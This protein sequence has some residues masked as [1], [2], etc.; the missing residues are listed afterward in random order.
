MTAAV[1]ALAFLSSVPVSAGPTLVISGERRARPALPRSV[2]VGLLERSL[3]ELPSAASSI[4]AER[5]GILGVRRAAKALTDDQSAAENYAPLGYYE[6]FAVRGFPL[7]NASAFKRNGLTIA[8]EASMPMENK[9]RVTLLKGAPGLEPGPAAPGGIVDY[10]TKRPGRRA[11]SRLI[12]EGSMT[13]GR[14]AALDADF[15]LGEAWGARVNAA[16]ESLRPYVTAA[17]GRRRFASLAVERSFGPAA[18]VVFDADWDLRSQLSVPAVQLLGGSALPAGVEPE[19]MLNAQPWSRPVRTEASNIGLAA[20]ARPEGWGLLRAAFNRN[21]VLM[22]DNVAFP[23]GCSSGPTTLSVFCA[24]G[25]Y[26]L[27]DY[28]SP[29][30]VRTVSEARLA[31]SGRFKTGALLHRPALGVSRMSREVRRGQEVFAFL[32]TANL[33]APQ[34]V[35]APSATAPGTVHLTQRADDLSF[36]LADTV[37]LSP[38]WKVLVGLRRSAVE[39]RRA[40][41]AA[42]AS[43]PGFSRVFLVPQAALSWVPSPALAFYASHVRG[44]EPGGTAPATAANAGAVLDPKESRQNELGMRFDWEGRLV[45]GLTAFRMSRPTEFVDASN[46]FSRRGEAVHQGLEGTLAGAP[47]A[48]TRLKAGF[49]W[50]R[51]R[52]RGTGD[53]AL[54]GNAPPNAASL[55]T[56][57]SASQTLWFLPGASLDGAWA[58]VS[59]SPARRDGAASVPSYHRF[60]AGARWERGAVVAALRVENLFDRRYWKDSG[61]AF[62]DGY[63]HLGA[64]RVVRV[65]TELKF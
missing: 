6:G 26:D 52:Q 34:P 62:G 14:Y 65:S 4:D 8:N 63:L 32:G 64:P 61:E 42:G 15:P 49:T 54:D 18:S 1:L 19:T 35:Y 58:F 60:D 27:Y 59:D 38:S 25:D 3:L 48:G 50:L 24:N 13:G 40:D 51:A 17:A 57:F 41:R 23:Y 30:E 44:V 39:E 45:G 22:D 56:G 36:S 33:S 37:A 28:R 9:E 29:G 53:P 31:W 2:R 11:S 46:A 12:L 55:R 7:D 43:R 5:L 21:R 16:A 10:E 20:E 47:A